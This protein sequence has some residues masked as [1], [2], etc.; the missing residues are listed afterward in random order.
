MSTAGFNPNSQFN[1]AQPVD[2][3]AGPDPRRSEVK[4][5]VNV[6]PQE[7]RILDRE[8]VVLNS[9]SGVKAWISAHPIESILIAGGLVY[10]A[11]RKRSE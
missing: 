5:D 11:T 2:A 3:L 10:L 9:S 8:P 7:G 1:P 6:P 4:Q